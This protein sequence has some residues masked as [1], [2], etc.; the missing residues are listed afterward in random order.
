MGALTEPGFVGVGRRWVQLRRRR[1]WHAWRAFENPLVG[2][3]LHRVVEGRKVGDAAPSERAEN[4]MVGEMWVLRQK[5]A[6][7]VRAQDS[8]LQVAFGAVTAVVALA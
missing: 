5:R 7:E 4:Q 2:G 3:H 8:A 1:V 6:V